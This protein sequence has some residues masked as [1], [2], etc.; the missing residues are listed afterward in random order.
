M[1]YPQLTFYQIDSDVI[2]DLE[3]WSQ[4]NPD[5]VPH[6]GLYDPPN[7]RREETVETY[8]VPCYCPDRLC[9]HMETLQYIYDDGKIDKKST[10]EFL[11]RNQVLLRPFDDNQSKFLDDFSLLLP[12]S[13]W[14]FCLL[15]R[16]WGKTNA[17][18][19]PIRLTDHDQRTSTSIL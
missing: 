18:S 10:A 12:R 16:T 2:I 8:P 4:Q 5:L 3:L 11:Q 13:I 9:T 1:T 15:N 7:P 19:Y 14:G 17:V 6:V